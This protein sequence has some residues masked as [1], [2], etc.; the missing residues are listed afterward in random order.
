MT[1]Q[2]QLHLC[3]AATEAGGKSIGFIDIDPFV[4]IEL[5][6][7]ET[8]TGE[9]LLLVRHHDHSSTPAAAAR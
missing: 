9:E 5:R 6:L 3:L 4:E 1:R 2:R 8:G 7:V